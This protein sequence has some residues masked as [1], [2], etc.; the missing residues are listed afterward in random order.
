MCDVEGSNY[1]KYKSSSFNI[2]KV[3]NK[4]GFQNNCS[5]IDETIYLYDDLNTTQLKPFKNYILI[6]S[7]NEQSVQGDLYEYHENT[8]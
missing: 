4:N 5:K 8:C 3:I 7:D 2:Q 1:N 6:Y